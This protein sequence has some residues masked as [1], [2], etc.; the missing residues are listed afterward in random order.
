MGLLGQRNYGKDVKIGSSQLS[1]YDYGCAATCLGMLNNRWGA[2]CTPVQVVEHL[3]WFTKTGLLLWNKLN[4]QLAVFEWRDYR[5]NM[6]KIQQYLADPENKGVMLQLEILHHDLPP[7]FH[8]VIAENYLQNGV[9]RVADPW[10]CAFQQTSIYGPV[11]G[12]AFFS[13]RKPS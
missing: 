10:T 6:D 8:W 9:F 13:K 5:V 4:L 3:D 11:V 2:N 12:A 7:S 1:L